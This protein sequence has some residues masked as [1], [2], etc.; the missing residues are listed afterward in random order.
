MTQP[1]QRILPRWRGFNLLD[2]FTASSTGNFDADELQ[3]IRDWGFDFVRLPMCYLL[4]VEGRGDDVYQIHEPMLDKLDRVVELAGRNGLHVCLNFH[5]APG[6]CVNRERDEP[7][8]LWKDADALDAC[9]F[10]WRLMAERYRGIPPTQLSFDLFNEPPEPSRRVMTRDDHERV[11]RAV[12]ADI[13][14]ISPGRAIIID[15]LEY[16]RLPCP[17]L[18]DLDVA[19]SCRGYDPL[20]VS[21]YMAEWVGGQMF[22]PPQWP[23]G[24]HGEETWDRRRLEEHYQPWIDL[25]QHGVGVHCGEAGAFNHTPHEIVLAWL[26]DVLEILTAANI[27]Y[28]LWNFTGP[29]GILDSDRP[30]VNYENHHGRKLDRKLLE[31]LQEF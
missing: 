8:S 7:F 24:W 10:H 20:G 14:E 25:A 5:R 9:R 23:G 30:D 15:G 22:P 4:W 12:V 1:A 3:W 18:A 29:F 17:E 31:L 13:H 19:Q 21:H 27:G 2:M 28:A 26:R 16:G 11:V 6:Y